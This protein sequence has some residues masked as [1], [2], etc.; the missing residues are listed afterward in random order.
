ME[1]DSRERERE[2]RG[3]IKGFCSHPEIRKWRAKREIFRLYSFNNLL[4]FRPENKL[5]FLQQC[6][7][8]QHGLFSESGGLKRE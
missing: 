6:S 1:E 3:G 5:V 7:E 8:V 4:L 2:R